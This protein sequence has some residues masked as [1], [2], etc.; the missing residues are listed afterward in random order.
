MRPLIDYGD[1]IYDQPQNEY[2]CEKIES[3]Q[4]KA[5]LA[6]TGAI[7]GTSRDKIYQE[8]GLESLKSRRWYKRLV[9]TFKIMNEKA[10]N[11]LIN[12]IPK[13]DP[14][15][16]TRNNSVPSYKCRV[17]CF[18]HSFFSFTLNDWFNL[19]INIRNS[20]SITLFK[21]RLLSFICAVQN[22][23]YNIFDP[24]GLKFLTRLR[25]GLSHLNAH[26]FRH[27]FQD[28][29]N[30]LRSCSLETED[31]SHYLLHCHHF[32]NHRAHLMNSVKSVCDNFESMSDNVKKNVLLYGDSRF[33]EVKKKIYLRRNYNLYKR[34]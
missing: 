27:N 30:P 3:V 10:P 25:L 16:R 18:K 11:Y 15:I 28:Y 8:L 34:L 21:C 12:L 9:S 33:D 6:I 7:Q 22:S 19:D 31:T 26:R 20:E 32:S 29:L 4:Y 14:T 2:F 17:N 23:I 13:H 1:I 5:T 24:K